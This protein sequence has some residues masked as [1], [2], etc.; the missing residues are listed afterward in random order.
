MNNK[1][2]VALFLYFKIIIMLF[3]CEFQIGL[4]VRFRLSGS[5]RWYRVPCR[6]CDDC[7][8]RHQRTFRLNFQRKIILLK[9]VAIHQNT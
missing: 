5:R 8:C 3:V 1:Q 2:I 4:A 6:R 7:T 9:N